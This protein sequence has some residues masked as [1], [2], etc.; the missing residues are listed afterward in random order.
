MVNCHDNFTIEKKE[1]INEKLKN[2]L[3]FYGKNTKKNNSS[4][5][6]FIFIYKK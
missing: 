5:L 1:L 6:S 3:Y 2:M 4:K